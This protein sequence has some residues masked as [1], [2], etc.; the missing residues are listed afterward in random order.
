[1]KFLI[2]AQLPETLSDLICTIGHESIHTLQLEKKNNTTDSEIIDV[3]IEDGRILV[4]KDSDFK[5]SHTMH[6][7][8]PKLILVTIGN[9]GNVELMKIFSENF[10]SIVE[11]ISKYDFVE[12]NNNSI[13][14]R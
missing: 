9:I 6:K 3:C 8:P 14:S 5:F 13:L 11:H 1:M 2:D 7:K 4:T 10:D 12:I